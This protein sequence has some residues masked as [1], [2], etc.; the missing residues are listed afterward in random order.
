[1]KQ[2][3]AMPSQINWLYGAGCFLSVEVFIAAF[4]HDRIVRPYVGDLLAVIF[5]YCLVKSL[6]EVPARPT[7]LAVLVV[8]YL[9][10]ISQYFHLATH[11]GV[12]HS[13]M[14]LLV[15]GSHFSWVD[16]AMYTLGALVLVAS[17]WAMAARRAT[18]RNCAY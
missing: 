18:Q 1:M 2:E 9:I 15:L 13:R 6:A 3:I 10:E 4:M 12:G 8:A 11:L 16:M 5:L 14:A 17:E 7:I